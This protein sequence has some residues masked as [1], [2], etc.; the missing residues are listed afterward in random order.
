[1]I[2]LMLRRFNFGSSFFA[3]KPFDYKA[4]TVFFIK[5]KSVSNIF[6]DYEN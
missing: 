1:M 6:L 5:F 4:D 3:L 2:A